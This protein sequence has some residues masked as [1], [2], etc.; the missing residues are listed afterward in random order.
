[1]NLGKRL[2]RRCCLKIF[3]FFALAAIL[4]TEQNGLCNFSTGNYGGDVIKDFLD[5]SILAMAPIL[6]DRAIPFVRFGYRALWGTFM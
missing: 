5:N 4:F 2:G 3:L 1:M 6:F